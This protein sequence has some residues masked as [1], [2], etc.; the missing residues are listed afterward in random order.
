MSD[1]WFASIHPSICLSIFSISMDSRIL[2]LLFGLLLLFMVLV[3]FFQFWA[4]VPFF[5]FLSDW[6]L[7]PENHAS[8]FL[9]TSFLS[10]T[11]RCSRLIFYFSCPSPVISYL[12]KEPWFFFT[13]EWYLAIDI[14]VL[15]VLIATGC[16]CFI[17]HI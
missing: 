4:L 10:G 3:K 11:T 8:P 12:S 7:C 13:K 5:F 16:H 17:F 14:W 15:G 9:N 6:F 1:L 2:I